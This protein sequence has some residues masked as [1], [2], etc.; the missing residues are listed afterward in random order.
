MYIMVKIKLGSGK[1][2]NKLIE[3]CVIETMANVNV[4]RQPATV[5]QH[6]N[7]K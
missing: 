3:L 7:G 4:A 1:K 2:S 5:D 6:E